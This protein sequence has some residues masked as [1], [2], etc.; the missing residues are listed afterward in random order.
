VSHRR[1]AHCLS[2]TLG[3]LLSM[4]PLKIGRFVQPHTS[5][6]F[7]VAAVADAEEAPWDHP[8]LFGLFTARIT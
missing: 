6:S 5:K 4:T 7:T 2:A 8:A 3:F 1:P